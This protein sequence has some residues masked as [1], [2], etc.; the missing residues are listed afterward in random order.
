MNNMTNEFL[1]EATGSKLEVSKNGDTFVADL[2][3]EDGNL[4]A[5]G[6]GD[7]LASALLSLDAE[8]LRISSEG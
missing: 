4:Y 1:S 3:W 7:S 8:V 6:K 2:F 5:A